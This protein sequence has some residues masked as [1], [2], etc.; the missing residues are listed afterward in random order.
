[1]TEHPGQQREVDAQDV[2]ELAEQLGKT[3]KDMKE[4]AG[5]GRKT[6]LLVRLLFISLALDIALTLTVAV[7]SVNALSRN[8]DVTKAQISACQTS[9]GDQLTIWNGLV[10]NF[11]SPNPTKA[12]ERRTRVF[13]NFV[14]SRLDPSRCITLYSHK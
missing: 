8:G 7:L 12:E 13:L 2:F 3:V 10:K 9:R 14:D 4:V 5:Y 6:R 11:T 1:M